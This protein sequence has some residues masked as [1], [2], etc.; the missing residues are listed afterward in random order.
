MCLHDKVCSYVPGSN[1][2]HN[3]QQS[4]ITWLILIMAYTSLIESP[5]RGQPAAD[6]ISMQIYL[7]KTHSDLVYN[8]YNVTWYMSEEKKS[9]I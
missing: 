8:T 2:C 5:R 7:N 3:I 6:L 9:S 1:K 4:N